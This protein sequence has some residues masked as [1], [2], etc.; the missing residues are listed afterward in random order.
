MATMAVELPE[1]LRDQVRDLVDQ[2]WFSSEGQLVQ[3]AV[4]RFLE[5]H[6]PELM[7]RFVRADVEWGLKGDD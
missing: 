7:T 4:R 2:G 3:E 6:T 5:T 1:Q